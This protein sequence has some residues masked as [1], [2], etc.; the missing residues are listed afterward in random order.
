MATTTVRCPADQAR[1]TLD[2]M[3]RIVW[4]HRK[5]RDPVTGICDQLLEMRTA[6]DAAEDLPHSDG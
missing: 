4:S 5:D 1:D 6:L 3:T 2:A